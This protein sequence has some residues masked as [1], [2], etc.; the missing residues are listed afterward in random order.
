M[1]ISDW[2]SVVCSSDLHCPPVRDLA[3][4]PD[5][6]RLAAD[7]D[8]DARRADA[9]P[10]VVRAAALRVLDVDVGHPAGFG[11]DRAVCDGGLDT[12]LVGAHRGSPAGATVTRRRS[13]TATV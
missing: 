12:G 6:Q 4:A 13:T 11:R 7:D 2:S 8:G 5:R 9:A 1:R 10:A 3:F